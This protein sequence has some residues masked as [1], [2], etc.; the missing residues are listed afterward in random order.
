MTDIAP[1]SYDTYSFK[2]HDGTT[3]Q[4]PPQGYIRV[5]PPDHFPQVRTMPSVPPETKRS[6]NGVSLAE[7]LPV[8]VLD[9]ETLCVT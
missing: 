8:M 6:P 5:L 2:K 1:F 4:R 9:A 7:I 3:V